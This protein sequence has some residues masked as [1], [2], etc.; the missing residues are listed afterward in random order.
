MSLSTRDQAV[1]WHPY[2]QHKTSQQALPISRGKGTY[3]YDEKGKAY[4]DLISSWWV[5]LHGHGHPDIAKAIYEQAMELDH[6]LFAGF[7]HEPAVALAEKILALAPAGYSKVF[8]SDNGSTAVEVGLKMAYQYWRNQGEKKRQRFI[9]FD[10]GYHGDTFGAMAVGKYCGYFEAFNDLFFAVDKFSYPETW[11]GDAFIEEKEQRVLTEIKDYLEKNGSE[12]CALIIEPLVQGSSGMH[13][14]RPQFLRELEKLIRAHGILIIYDEVLTSLGRCGDYFACHK[15]GTSPDIICVS[16][17]LTG[18]FLPCAMT[19]CQEKIYAAFLGD[20]I[21]SALIHGHTFT[22]NPI[23][24]AAGLASMKLLE[25]TETQ[26]QIALIEKIHTEELPRVLETGSVE[27]GRYCG[28]IMA[29]DFKIDAAYGSENSL[30]LRKKFNDRGLLIRP[31]GKVLYF[32]PPYCITETELRNAY[33]IVIEE[34][35][36]VRA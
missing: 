27:H 19:L 16:K 33:N 34:L 12:I 20:S 23:A 30:A 8:Y 15:A 10:G 13:M 17:G 26:K 1:V 5:T 24:C 22:A 11:L 21:A 9:A 2:T 4:L 7:T 3:V 35:Q 31:I 6:V 36:G 28:T 18:G 14:C 29:V 25:Q 32:L